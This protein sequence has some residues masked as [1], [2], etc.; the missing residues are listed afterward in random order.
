MAVT[1]LRRQPNLVQAIGERIIQ[2]ILLVAAS[3][4]VLTTAGIVF[5]LLFETIAFFNEVSIVE[6]LTETEWTPLFATKKFGIWPLASATFLT[7]AIA[8]LVAVPVSG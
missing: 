1:D 3:I 8:M 2:I 7:S 6:F 5:S 4:S